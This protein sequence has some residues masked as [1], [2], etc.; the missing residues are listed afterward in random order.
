MPLK[1]YQRLEKKFSVV[2][3]ATNKVVGSPAWF[4]FSIV[5]IALWIPSRFL[6]ETEELWHLYIN[7]FTTIFTFLM[8]SLLHASQSKWEKKI[9][10]LQKREEQTIKLLGKDTSEIK[11]N[12][13]AQQ[14]QD[15]GNSENQSSDSENDNNNRKENKSTQ[16]TSLL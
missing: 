12:L 14:E 13:S 7:T 9:E 15:N 3:N 5:V 11:S 2:S 1:F 6:F 4:V 10:Q 8:M 16:I